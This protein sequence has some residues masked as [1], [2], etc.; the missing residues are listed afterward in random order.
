ML[1]VQLVIIIAVSARLGGTTKLLTA[2][3]AA[4]YKCDC[5][6]RVACDTARAGP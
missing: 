5:T 2:R 4:L 6:P 3:L 1:E